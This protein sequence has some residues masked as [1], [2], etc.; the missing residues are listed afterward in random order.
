MFI[1]VSRLEDSS[2]IVLARLA[3]V[4]YAPHFDRL[5]YM[6]VS[7]TSFSTPNIVG[8]TS[9]TETYF[10]RHMPSSVPTVSGK[11]LKTGSADYFKFLQLLSKGK[12]ERVE[13]V[14]NRFLLKVSKSRPIVKHEKFNTLLSTIPLYVVVNEYDEM[15]ISCAPEAFFKAETL[16][17]DS[18]INAREQSWKKDNPEISKKLLGLYFLNKADAE[19]FMKDVELK[20]PLVA[21]RVKL[22]IKTVPLLQYFH[23]SRAQ[24]GNYDGKHKNSQFLLVPDLLELQQLISTERLRSFFGTPIFYIETIHLPN[25][26]AI[27]RQSTEGSPVKNGLESYPVLEKLSETSSCFS[28]SCKGKKIAFT[29]KVPCKGTLRRPFFM[30]KRDAI[31]LYNAFRKQNPKLKLPK[32]AKLGVRSLEN[33]LKEFEA[34]ME[35]NMANEEDLILLIPQYSSYLE[36]SKLEALQNHAQM[37]KWG[38]N[39]AYEIYRRGRKFLKTLKY[40]WPQLTGTDLEEAQKIPSISC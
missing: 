2:F 36:A 15:V 27:S 12:L 17:T 3:W 28:P 32:T 37:N 19:L 39:I 6:W 14:K 18:T 24:I 25:S 16:S 5:H 11:P 31:Q 4:D 40:D 20:D 35:A 13:G 23:A 10:N 9:S 30:S 21:Q 7:S 38:N 29:L 8:A 22:S 34:T 1:H 33:I 26:A